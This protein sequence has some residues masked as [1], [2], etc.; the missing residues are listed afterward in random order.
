MKK[1][2]SFLGCAGQIII[3]CGFLVFGIALLATLGESKLSTYEKHQAAT[4]IGKT[5]V[6][7]MSV[8]ELERLPKGQRFGWNEIVGLMNG[9]IDEWNTFTQAQRDIIGPYGKFIIQHLK[10]EKPLTDE[11]VAEIEQY[12]VDCIRRLN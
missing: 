11:E 3:I 7:Y 9:Q 5:H 12:Y 10:D 4:W 1:K 8:E 2:R 6:Y